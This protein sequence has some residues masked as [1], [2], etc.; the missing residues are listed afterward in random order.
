[1]YTIQLRKKDFLA[2]ARVRVISQYFQVLDCVSNRFARNISWL[3]LWLGLAVNISILGLLYNTVAQE[4]DRCS[5][6]G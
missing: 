1:M 4:R 2:L 5:R 3:S 6:Y